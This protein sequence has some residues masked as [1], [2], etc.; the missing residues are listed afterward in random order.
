MYQGGRKVSWG[1][2]GQEPDSA[3]LFRLYVDYGRHA[4]ATNL[5]LEN[6]DSF[7]SLVTL[8]CCQYLEICTIFYLE[9]SVHP[10][11]VMCVVYFNYAHVL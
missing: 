7:S 2:T 8:H 4:E 9:L 10:V 1:M 11:N 5:L 3:T 6:L